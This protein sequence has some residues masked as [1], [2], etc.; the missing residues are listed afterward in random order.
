M[1]NFLLMYIDN[2]KLCNGTGLAVGEIIEGGAL[3]IGADQTKYVMAAKH[4]FTGK[5]T[6]MFITCIIIFNRSKTIKLVEDTYM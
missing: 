6:G 3:T 2:T 1:V 4:Q 5:I